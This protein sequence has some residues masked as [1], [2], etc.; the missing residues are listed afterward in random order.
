MV[1]VYRLAWLTYA[2]ARLL[3][4]VNHIGMVNIVAGDRVV[5]ELIQSD[6]T[7]ERILAETQRI[8]ENKDLRDHM[9]EKLGEVREGLGTPGAPSRVAD[10]A[11]SLMT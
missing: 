1:I 3:V 4:H 8:L 7:A 11:L 2:L 9:V 6:V 10:M 5:P